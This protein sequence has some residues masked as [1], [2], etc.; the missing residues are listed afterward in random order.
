MVHI[1]A[2]VARAAVEDTGLICL[3]G[4]SSAR[5]GDGSDGDHCVHESGVVVEGDGGIAGDGSD[6]LLA[7][8]VAG[9][10]PHLIGPL[11]LRGD[12]LGGDVVEGQLLGR[13]A[14]AARAA[15][16][17][18]VGRAGQDLLLGEVEQLA[19][20]DGDV[21]LQRLCRG[22]RP[23]PTASALVL[24]RGHDALLPPVKGGG[25][26]RDRHV[27]AQVSLLGVQG[28]APVQAGADDE[29]LEL[30]AGEAGELHRTKE[31][32]V[33]WRRAGERP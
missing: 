18:G 30:L 28:H 10:G 16:L 5:D 4:L 26:R 1:S 32:G 20:L 29:V 7:S 12:A 23:A 8:P 13:A 9:A 11:C 33:G 19:S 21:A 6:S 15:A 22:E 27:A 25:Q 24:D 3:P 17:V 2:N 14:A 31:G